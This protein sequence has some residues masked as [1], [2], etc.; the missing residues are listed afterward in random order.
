[1][2]QYNHTEISLKFGSSQQFYKRW[3]WRRIRVFKLEE[4]W[5]FRNV[6]TFRLITLTRRTLSQAGNSSVIQIFR[7]FTSQTH[8]LWLLSGRHS[9][10]RTGTRRFSKLGLENWKFRHEISLGEHRGFFLTI[11]PFKMISKRKGT[12]NERLD[13]NTTRNTYDFIANFSS[14]FESFQNFVQFSNI[15]SV[16]SLRWNSVSRAR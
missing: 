1:M 15:F 14:F 5:T 3:H 10:C 8:R 6:G 13:L 11:S 7:L 16:D 2:Y 12:S 9:F 4:D